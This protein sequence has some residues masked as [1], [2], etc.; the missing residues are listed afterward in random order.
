VRDVGNSKDKVVKKIPLKQ[1]VEYIFEFERLINEMERNLQKQHQLTNERKSII[2][3]GKSSEDMKLELLKL[4]NIEL[5]SLVEQQKMI[6]KRIEEEQHQIFGLT[7]LVG[8]VV[9]V[10]VA[11][12][13]NHR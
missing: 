2:L 1:E 13:R 12:V 8:M 7:M 10:I 5:I 3:E 11:V 6:T 4:L 9:C